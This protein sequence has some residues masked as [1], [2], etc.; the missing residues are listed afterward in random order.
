M[1]IE[2]DE[3]EAPAYWASYLVNGDAS[4]LEDYELNQA[5]A[6]ERKLAQDGWH[7]VSCG[8]SYTGRW[9]VYDYADL[10]IYTIH[11]SVK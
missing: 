11:K 6:F 10:V 9:K 2:V 8:E 3:V 7:I 1:S 4:G 5:R